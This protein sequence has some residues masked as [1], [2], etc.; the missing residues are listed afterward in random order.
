MTWDA[1]HR[2]AAVAQAAAELAET[3]RDGVLPW[4]E[5]SGATDAFGTPERLVGALQMRWHTR[6]AGAIERELAN[7]P[8]EL[9]RSVVHAWRRCEAE[10]PGLRAV[11][12]AHADTPTMSVAARKEWLLLAS[13]SGAAG[14]GDAGAARRGEQIEQR[15]RA[16]RLDITPPDRPRSAVLRRLRQVL[17]A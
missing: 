8:G 7:E 10:M 9:E 3:R 15:A 6:L 16:V 5:L 1:Y 4:S 2:R 14:L 12:D 13:A 17:A 11:L